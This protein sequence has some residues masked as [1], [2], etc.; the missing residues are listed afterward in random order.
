MSDP[1]GLWRGWEVVAL[2]PESYTSNLLLVAS[3]MGLENIR[4]TRTSL[5][6]SK[7]NV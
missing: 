3:I 6:I 1:I 2:S 5:L 7:E 4:T